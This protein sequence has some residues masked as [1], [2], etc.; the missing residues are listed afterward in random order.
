MLAPSV[1]TTFGGNIGAL[2]HPASQLETVVTAQQA[3]WAAAMTA[4]EIT[5][6]I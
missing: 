4:P 6:K 2:R 5:T 3:K 1:W